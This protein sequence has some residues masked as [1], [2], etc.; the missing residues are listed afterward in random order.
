MKKIVENSLLMVQNGDTKGAIEILLPQFNK[1]KNELLHASSRL[2]NLESENNSG[3]IRFEE[4]SIERNKVSKSVISIIDKIEKEIKADEKIAEKENSE[5]APKII[6]FDEILNGNQLVKLMRSANAWLISNDPIS[7]IDEVE[8][9]SDFS[10]YL[11]DYHELF[12][13]AELPQREFLELEVKFN[14]KIERLNNKGFSVYAK[15]LNAKKMGLKIGILMT[16]I[17][18]STNNAIISDEILKKKYLI[19][20]LG[21]IR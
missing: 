3:T 4:F 1:Y 15:I 8:I 14:S 21:D 2:A 19:S 10:T 12:G 6:R 7:N 17:V 20:I 18:R 16:C 9:V 11:E 13:V 5:K